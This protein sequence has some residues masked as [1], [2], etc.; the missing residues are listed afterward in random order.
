MHLETS[1]KRELKVVNQI[2]RVCDNA[3]QTYT[4]IKSLE[5]RSPAT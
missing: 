3:H 4:E 1:I 5:H 2:C